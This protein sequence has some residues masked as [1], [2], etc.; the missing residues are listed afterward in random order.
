MGK[1]LQFYL[2][3]NVLLLVDVSELT[4]QR[5][6]DQEDS[7]NQGQGR[8]LTQTLPHEPKLQNNK[9]SDRFVHRDKEEFLPLD[10]KKS[11]EPN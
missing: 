2:Q 10:S 11:I 6:L 4:A 7:K 1:Y 3:T 9:P 5:P 8:T